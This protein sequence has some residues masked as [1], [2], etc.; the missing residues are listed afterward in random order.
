MRAITSGTAATTEEIVIPHTHAVSS[1]AA[2]IRL[3]GAIL[4]A[5]YKRLNIPL[6][7]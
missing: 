3:E 1:F 6:L 2:F 4:V 5:D 7:D